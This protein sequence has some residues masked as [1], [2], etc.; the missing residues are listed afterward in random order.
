GGTV[1]TGLLLGGFT[2]AAM[3]LAGRINGGALLPTSIGLFLVGSAIGLAVSVVAGLV[4]RGD[5][6]SW[7]D[8]G[9]DAAKGALYAIPACLVGAVL[10]G[11]M[12]MVV[13]GLYLGRALP[14]AGSALAAVVGLGVMAGTFKVTCESGANVL[15]RVRQ[16][17]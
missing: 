15:R 9:R 11:W 14:V 7:M 12:G 8:A 3:A 17:M 10:A 2:V 5:G 13:I 6:W 1:S 16:V 4:G